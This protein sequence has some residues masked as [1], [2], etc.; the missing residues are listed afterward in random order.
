TQMRKV[1]EESMFSAGKIEK[2]Y[3]SMIEGKLDEKSL[4]WIKIFEDAVMTLQA[5]RELWYDFGNVK[6]AVEDIS[7]KYK[8]YPRK[9]LEDVK[10]WE[11]EYK[12]IKAEFLKGDFSKRGRIEEFKSLPTKPCL[13]IQR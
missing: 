3:N 2:K 1:I 12:A 5:E 10:K 13:Q 7:K 6:A 4:E 8:A 11:G 9:Y